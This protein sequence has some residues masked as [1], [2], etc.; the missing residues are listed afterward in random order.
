MFLPLMSGNDIRLNCPH[1]EFLQIFNQLLHRLPVQTAVR[2]PL[3][4]SM[5]VLGVHALNSIT[6][7]WKIMVAEDCIATAAVQR[8]VQDRVRL[9]FINANLE[10]VAVDSAKPLQP[11][12]QDFK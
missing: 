11:S 1:P 10:V 9:W 12:L 6:N 2:Q 7:I 5:A 8:M 3:G 4:D